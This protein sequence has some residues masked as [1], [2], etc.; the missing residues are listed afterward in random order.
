MAQGCWHVW[1]TFWQINFRSLKSLPLSSFKLRTF[2]LLFTSLELTNKS[3]LPIAT[4][5]LRNKLLFISHRNKRRYCFAYRWMSLNSQNRKEKAKM[6]FLLQFFNKKSLWEYLHFGLLKCEWEN[7]EQF[8][9]SFM[10]V[11]IIEMTI[12]PLLRLIMY[13]YDNKFP[14]K[15]KCVKGW[16]KCGSRNAKY[17]S[18]SQC[19]VAF[20]CD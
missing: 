13:F 19:S 4:E 9:E 3:K 8:S 20:V 10:N 5:L 1:W 2:S 18:S 16:E 7:R 15:L 6:N 17:C 11:H 12:F 14:L